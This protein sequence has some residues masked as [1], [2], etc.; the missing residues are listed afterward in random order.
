MHVL[1]NIHSTH[2][3]R[4]IRYTYL[5]LR[6]RQSFPFPLAFPPLKGEQIPPPSRLLSSLI[7]PIFTFIFIFVFIFHKNKH[8]LPDGLELARR[9]RA[10]QPSQ[11]LRISVVGDEPLAGIFEAADNEAFLWGAGAVEFDGVGLL[12]LYR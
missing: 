8:R 6:P 11:T 4:C 10:S 2:Y 9:R 3:I 12:G 5:Q 7:V 1:Y